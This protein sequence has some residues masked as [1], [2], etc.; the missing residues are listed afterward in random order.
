M[1]IVY[2]IALLA[3][4][5]YLWGKA[6]RDEIAGIIFVSLVFGEVST[7]YRTDSNDVLDF[8]A[9]IFFNSI[10]ALFVIIVVLTI[11]KFAIKQGEGEFATY[12]LTYSELKLK[13]NS[14]SFTEEDKKRLEYLK[15]KGYDKE[16]KP[17]R[18][19]LND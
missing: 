15:A 17:N 3:L 1:T 16:F 11:I 12:K 18:F 14:D 19:E 4:P 7:L 8:I 6:K 13:E 9:N 10:G 5:I 2:I